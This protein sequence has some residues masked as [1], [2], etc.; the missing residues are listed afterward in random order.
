MEASLSSVASRAQTN[1]LSV[2]PLGAWC[3]PRLTQRAAHRCQKLYF[4]RP[5]LTAFLLI[6]CRAKSG[7]FT[8]VASTRFALCVLVG[9]GSFPPMLPFTPFPSTTFERICCTSRN[10]RTLYPVFLDEKR[11][12]GV[13]ERYWCRVQLQ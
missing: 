9:W 2:C 13:C 5:T 8:T 3:R 12:L 1:P 11:A 10:V 7:G 6:N 4:H